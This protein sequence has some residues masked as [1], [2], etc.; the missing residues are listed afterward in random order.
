MMYLL[1]MQRQSS[2][3]WE[4][5]GLEKSKYHSGIGIQPV[6]SSVQVQHFPTRTVFPGHSQGVLP[7][8]F[9]LLSDQFGET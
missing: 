8:V 1:H 4:E 6:A 5:R 3:W 9:N 2:I 7:S